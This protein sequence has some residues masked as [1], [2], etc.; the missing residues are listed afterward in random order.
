MP[1]KRWLVLRLQ[2]PLLA[3]GGV[4]IDHVG[5]TRDFPALSMLTGLLANVLGWERTEW[6]KHQA[7]QDRLIFAARLDRDETGLLTDTQN[8]RLEKNDKGWTTWG[9]LEGRDGASYGAPHR[10]RREYH[11][12][13]CILV[14]L[15]LEPDAATPDLDT[16]AAA[17][18]RPARP[19]FIG[20]KPCLP[21][22]PLLW[23]ADVKAFDAHAALTL[24]TADSKSPAKAM[25]AIWPLGEGPEEGDKVTRIL[26]LPD[27][28]NWR[29]G[30]HGGTRKVV[31]GTVSAR[32]ISA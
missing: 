4:A 15:R 12:D 31:E 20:R 10:R 24:A 18:D 29:T 32:E 23:R 25:R 3:F 9:K 13:A 7:L 26:D 5:I 1:E 11:M 8:A 16:L 21:S 17:L 30:L 19:I 28:R 27:L 22:T 2:A 14:A 6:Q